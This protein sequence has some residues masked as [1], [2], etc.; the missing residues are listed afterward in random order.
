MTLTVTDD[1]GG[2]DTATT[3][4]TIDAANQAPTADPNGPYTGTVGVAVTFDG[5]GST[6]PDGTIVCLRL[7]L[8]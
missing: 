4:A 5:S 3:T 6:D 2:S 7:G 1:A 8:R